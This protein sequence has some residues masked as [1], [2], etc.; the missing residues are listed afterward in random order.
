MDGRPQLLS[1]LMGTI[2]VR[3][4]TNKFVLDCLTMKSSRADAIMILL[5][6]TEFVLVK[7]SF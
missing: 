1:L 4:G 5:K 2:T 7:F 6:I 3:S